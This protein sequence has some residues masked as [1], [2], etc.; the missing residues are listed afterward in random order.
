MCVCASMYTNKSKCVS[1][2]TI[3]M[4]HICS[5]QMVIVIYCPQLASTWIR[6]PYFCKVKLTY[7]VV[8]CQILT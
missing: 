4:E 7:L 5:E 6:S 1:L 3:F 2:L 8:I